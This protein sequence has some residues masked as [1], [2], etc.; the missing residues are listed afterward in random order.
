M[1]AISNWERSA[2]ICFIISVIVACDMVSFCAKFQ[3]DR[4]NDGRDSD[5]WICTRFLP[6]K[7]SH[8]VV[9]SLFIA[10]CVL[11]NWP[12]D[13]LPWVLIGGD[14]ITWLSQTV[15]QLNFWL[16]KSPSFPTHC[17]R[18]GGMQLISALLGPIS[19]FT[20]QTFFCQSLLGSSCSCLAK[21][22]KYKDRISRFFLLGK[23]DGPVRRY[24][25]I[26]TNKTSSCLL[27]SS[28]L[29]GLFLV[30]KWI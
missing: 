1:L 10:A 11:L 12:R 28:V 17:P 27:N 16:V 25:S 26:Y 20:L 19:K 4:V 8:V 15:G 7:C 2:Q 23:V 30:V 13:S 24:T 3:S 6:V 21:P 18:V 14:L 5:G 9:A 22:F 29:L